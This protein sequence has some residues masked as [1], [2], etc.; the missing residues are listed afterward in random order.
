ESM[1][2]EEKNIL[3]VRFSSIG[4][5]ILTTP[6]IRCLRKKYPKAKIHYL[7]KASFHSVLEANPYLDKVWKWEEVLENMSRLKAENFNAIVDLH[8]NLRSQKI[9]RFLGVQSFS[10]DKLNVR[11]WLWVQT[12]NK[13]IM[14]AKHLVD[15]YFEGLSE[16]NVEYDGKGLDYFFPPET[17]MPEQLNGLNYCGIVLGAAHLT[18]QIPLS[19][20]EDL[21]PRIKLPIVLLGGPGDLEKS[22]SLE[23]KFPQVINKVAKSSLHE[24]AMMVKN[25][26][27]LITSDTGLMHMGAAFKTP[28]A[29]LWGNTAPEL[30]LYPFEHPQFKNFEVDGLSCR[31]CSKIGKKK[32]PKGHFKCMLTQDVPAIAS[33]INSF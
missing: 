30:G 12:K 33:Y 6:I 18:K 26:K 24:S 8:K 14:P 16:W 22:K 5:I 27:A 32:C 17:K 9:K 28:M 4:D 7:T 3:I 20:I 1:A 19:I 15:R 23:N 13:S 29:V 25:A 21:I 31:P 10:F 11:K 2:G